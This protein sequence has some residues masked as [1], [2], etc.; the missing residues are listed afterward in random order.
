MNTR[1]AIPEISLASAFNPLDYKV[2][3]Q[4]PE[5]K[6]QLPKPL[7]YPPDM[8]RDHTTRDWLDA[9]AK[10]IPFSF[11]YTDGST[12]SALLYLGFDLCDCDRDVPIS[13]EMYAKWDWLTRRPPNVLCGDTGQVHT[14]SQKND[15]QYI[16]TTDYGI[17]VYLAGEDCT[18]WKEGDGTQ[19]CVT[20]GR[21]GNVW[22]EASSPTYS[23]GGCLSNFNGVKYAA[24]LKASDAQENTDTKTPNVG[25]K[26]KWNLLNPPVPNGKDSA[27]DLSQL[28]DPDSKTL[29]VRQEYILAHNSRGKCAKTFQF[30]IQPNS[31]DS[32]V[33][34]NQPWNFDYI[35]LQNLVLPPY[36]LPNTTQTVQ[37]AEAPRGSM[38]GYLFVP[39]VLALGVKG[40]FDWRD[41][42]IKKIKKMRLQE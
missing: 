25:F 9:G 26:L 22:T 4:L 11:K 23:G 19:A 31:F 10:K 21:N 18:P 15:N 41:G 36:V 6:A 33:L 37:V 8:S 20:E 42:R 3:L 34:D 2:N 29:A 39:I 14:R 7:M 30:S 28:Y 38:P 1:F 5:I 16:E 24:F 13:I 32:T 40:F 27:V 35:G 17:D 12:Q